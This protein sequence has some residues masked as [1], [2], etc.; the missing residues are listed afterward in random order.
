VQEFHDTQ[1]VQIENRSDA[2]K[3]KLDAR[4]VW[5]LMSSATRIDVAKGRR[6]ETFVPSAE[7]QESI[8]KEVVGRSGNLR[9]PTVQMGDVFLVGFNEKLYAESAFPFC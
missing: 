6:V 1:N 8:L 5:A 7:T 3:E 2:R 9:A 4:A